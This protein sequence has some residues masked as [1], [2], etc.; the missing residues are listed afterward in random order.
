MSTA[1]YPQGM[2]TMSA[3]GR[4]NSSFPSQ[5][6]SWKGTGV[7][8]NPI[9]IAPSHVRPLTNRDSGNVFQSGSFP[10]RYPQHTR[11]FIPRPLKHYRRGRVIPPQEIENPYPN[12]NAAKMEVDL[13]NYNMNRYV[14]SSEGGSVGNGRSGHG[15]VSYIQDIPGGYT[16]KQNEEIVYEGINMA[17]C[18]YCETVKGTH[19]H[20]N[21]GEIGVNIA[22]SGEMCKICMK[23][24]GLKHS[25]IEEDKINKDCKTCEG[26]GVVVDYMPT[27][28]YLT[29]NPEP[30]S[31]TPSFC[32]NEQYK[33]KRR[34]IYAST[35]LK[36][37]YYT[38]HFQYMQNRCKTYNQRIFNFQDNKV[39][40]T[41]DLINIGYTPE[42]IASAKP[43][44]A[45]SQLNIYDAN[46]YPNAEIYEATELAIVTATLTQ[47]LNRG[48][49]SKTQY[50]T[51]I[52]VGTTIKSLFDLTRSFSEEFI[53]DANAILYYNLKLPSLKDP[54]IGRIGLIA[55]RAGCKKV[56]YKPNNYQFAKQGAVSSST[57]ML[58]LTVDTISTN[59]AS[60]NKNTNIGS[61]LYSAN[62]LYRG[63][64][65]YVANLYKNKSQEKC[66]APPAALIQGVY[67]YKNKKQCAYQ[68]QLPEYRVPISQ[69]S[70][71]RY[72]KGV[73]FPSGHYTQTPRTYQNPSIQLN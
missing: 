15:L 11:N 58:K 67:P 13:I 51:F 46:C 32:C 63:N 69:P 34:S 17:P 5:Y 26:V 25:H 21:V 61:G 59:A 29:D 56:I 36:K 72:Y 33:A 8:S 52:T 54:S 2:R 4:R 14:K 38:S 35:N 44:S 66:N 62:E 6:I 22:S 1:Y 43:G 53:N 7:F 9:G 49:I 57:R 70:P 39:P 45:L 19:Y 40:V 73:V 50:D 30:K 68:K 37:G 28:N 10:S 71:Y 27:T 23:Y 31:Q 48:F 12:N 41:Q 65:N 64:N 3:G 18:E 42:Q 60:M 24:M 47:Y 16:V 20:S 55:S